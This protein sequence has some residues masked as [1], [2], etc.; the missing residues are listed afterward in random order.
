LVSSDLGFA[1][2]HNVLDVA[3]LVSPLTLHA[4][5]SRGLSMKTP[6]AIPVDGFKLHY[7]GFIIDQTVLCG[8]DL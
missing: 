4:N 5:K 7:S 6:S 8:N 2:G 3:I 1:G